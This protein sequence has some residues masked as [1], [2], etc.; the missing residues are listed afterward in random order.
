LTIGFSHDLGA[1]ISGGV[2]SDLRIS[3]WFND[4]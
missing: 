4:F 3:E 2:R 1:I